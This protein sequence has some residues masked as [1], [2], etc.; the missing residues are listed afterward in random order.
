ML[1]IL[2]LSLPVVQAD[3]QLSMN[4]D[5]FLGNI[6]TDWPGSM[7]YDGF[8]YSDYWNQVTPENGTKWGTVEGTTRSPL[9]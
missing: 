2:L 7:N 9:T 1:M 6:T 4:P 8:I 5:K 3:A